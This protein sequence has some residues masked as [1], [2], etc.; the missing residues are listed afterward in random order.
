MLR[1]LLYLQHT[2]KTRVTSYAHL[3]DADF[4]QQLSALLVLHEEVCEA[5]QHSCIMPPIPT[6][7]YLVR[8]ED[9]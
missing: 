3:C 7:E 8:P 2:V 5:T 6:E 4:L 9:A 1:L